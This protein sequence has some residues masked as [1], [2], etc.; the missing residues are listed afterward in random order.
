MSRRGGRGG[1]GPK[2][3]VSKE[4]LK[5]SAA[6]AGLD[7]RHLK[8]LTDIT[9]P[10]L[11][12]DFLWL[13]TGKYWDP[14]NSNNNDQ[15]SQETTELVTTKRS[16]AVVSMMNKQRELT[17][18][19]QAG[20][21][22]V[23]PTAVI[24]VVRYSNRSNNKTNMTTAPDAIVTAS[25]G[26]TN[27]KLATDVRYFPVELL[28]L[29]TKR[30]AVVRK[31]TPSIDAAVVKLEELASKESTVGAAAVAQTQEDD[32]DLLAE[33]PPEEEEE[34]EDYTT[35]YYNTDEE[36]DGDDGEPTF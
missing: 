11:F 10:P 15:P 22:Y 34:G 8:V 3:S 35:N 4:L 36:S 14:D 23:R 32:E 17:A 31:L 29:Q 6:E 16:A 33:A 26:K 21:H 28:N 7:D 1:G 20:P 5:R 19:M 18:R 13:S 25:M 9:R 12:P 27:T 24:D 2:V 30:A